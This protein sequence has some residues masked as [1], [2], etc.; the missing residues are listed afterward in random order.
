V[1]VEVHVGGG[2][3]HRHRRAERKSAP[4]LSFAAPIPPVQRP[5]GRVMRQ[6]RRR[7]SRRKRTLRPADR[8]RHLARPGGAG[9]ALE[10]L[11]SRASSAFPASCGRF[12]ALAMTWRAHRDGRAFVL[13]ESVAA[14]GAGA[15][16]EGAARPR[17]S[18]SAG[19]S[20]DYSHLCH[21][22]RGGQPPR[23]DLACAWPGA[24]TP[25]AG[26]AAAGEHSS[27]SRDRR[28]PA[29]RCSRRHRR[30]PSADERGG[31]DRGGRRAEALPRGLPRRTVRNTRRSPHRIGGHSS[32]ARRRVLASVS[33]HPRRALPG[34]TPEFSRVLGCCAS[35]SNPGRIPLACRP[36]SRLP[37]RA[38]S[39]SRREPVPVR[40]PPALLDR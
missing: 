29:R 8:D 37:P 12:A 9:Q 18:T 39:S 13:P 25:C 19:T 11:G 1:R 36:S 17:C 32:E 35:R 27:S 30:I 21:S 23:S 14:G 38:S 3:L 6:L 10:Q 26:I 31:S 34:R 5:D 22:W 2:S 28:A 15:R 16:R 40:I 24:G 33:A 20:A 7:I 4:D